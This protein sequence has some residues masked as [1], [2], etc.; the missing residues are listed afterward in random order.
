MLLSPPSSLLA[1]GEGKDLSC[2]LLCFASLGTLLLSNL[3][4]SFFLQ[5]SIPFLSKY[6]FT[7]SFRHEIQ[8]LFL[9]GSLASL[10]EK[11]AWKNQANQDRLP[12]A[13]IHPP[14]YSRERN[15][16]WAASDW[17]NDCKPLPTCT[18]S[19]LTCLKL[20]KCSSILLNREMFPWSLN[21]SMY[22]RAAR[23]QGNS[24]CSTLYLLKHCKKKSNS[25]TDWHFLQVNSSKWFPSAVCLSSDITFRDRRN[26]KQFN[27]YNLHFAHWA[28]QYCSSVIQ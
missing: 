3:L 27:K 2:S 26:V 14:L 9:K 7:F 18:Q 5:N 8:P 1:Q 19:W 23:N 25:P 6:V 12:L 28:N 10:E 11:S 21:L 20:N 17:R 13:W 4:P 24:Q 15:Q 16:L 22:L